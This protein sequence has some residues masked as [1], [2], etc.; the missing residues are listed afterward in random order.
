MCAQVYGVVFNDRMPKMN[1][2]R[3]QV[4]GGV[5]VFVKEAGVGR[6][7]IQCKKYTMKP[8][9]WEDV[10]DEVSKAD[11]HNTPIKKLILATTAPND[12]PLLKK[13]QELS[14]NRETQGLF[15]VEV[16]FWEDI[17]NHID[18]FPVLQD[19]YAPH[20]PGAAFHRQEASLNAISDI[21]LETSATVRS[22][23]GL[24]L[25]RPDSVDRLISQQL[26]RTNELLKAGR[27][28][29]ALDHLAVVGKDPGPFDEKLAGISRK[30]S[31]SGSCAW[32]TRS[33]PAFFS[34]LSS[35]IRTT[36]AWLLPRFGAS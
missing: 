5:D 15:P 27:Y 35:S 8:V 7:G 11:K 14:D 10:E 32:T 26:D 33:L 4:Q 19:S 18:R 21:V 36:S 16:E 20:T 13:V 25:A 3:G 9:K 28:R 29:D 31:A 2:R 1:G 24:P 23:A 6:V 34:R 12:A 22:I 17:C 30:V